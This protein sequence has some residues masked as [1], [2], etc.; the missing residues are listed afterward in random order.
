[1]VEPS[2]HEVPAAVPHPARGGRLVRR[3]LIA[4]L[5]IFILLGILYEAGRHYLH[6][7]HATGQIARQLEATYGGHVEVG[8]LNVGLNG[9]SAQDVHLFE[10]G[11]GAAHAAWAVIKE[12]R[13]DL[14]LWDLLRGQT[15]PHELILAGAAVTLRFD[16]EGQLLTQIARS[17]TGAESLPVVKVEHGEITIEQQG[18]KPLVVSGIDG[19]LQ[20]EGSQ[21]VVSGSVSDPYWK[22][23][24]LSGV[25]DRKTGE[26]QTT[27]K[28]TGLH[29]T[30]PMLEDLPFVSPTVWREVQLEGDTAIE[31]QARVE[32]E[33]RKFHYRVAVEPQHTHVHVTAIELTAEQAHGQVVVEDEVVQLK[34]LQGQVA[35]GELTVGRAE[36]NFRATPAKLDFPEIRCRDLDVSRLPPSWSLPPQ[37]TGRLTGQAHL[38]L[39]LLKDRTVT[40]GEG[41]G[42]INDARVGGQPAEPIR[43]ELHATSQGFQFAN[44]QPTPR[45]GADIGSTRASAASGSQDAAMGPA[46]L[47]ITELQAPTAQPAEEQEFLPAWAA[48]QA[49]NL[50]DRGVAGLEKAGRSVLSQMPKMLGGPSRLPPRR[51][52]TWKSICGCGMWTWS[53]LS[54]VWS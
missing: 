13:T 37:V 7:R 34:E 17:T 48:Y 6:S 32:P 24:T 2:R 8:G 26:V 42:V 28:T 25:I 9:T 3:V 43:L 21:V 1:M 46:L 45:P 52:V 47:V 50:V 22:G 10:A 23:W 27:L 39:T 29:V 16:N 36:L 15:S 19:K 11:D 53:S 54:T 41:E 12:A 14:S 20:P 30:Q 5:V 44:I 51:P 18:R 40:S 31:F 49:V 33:T 38:R 4:L 35:G